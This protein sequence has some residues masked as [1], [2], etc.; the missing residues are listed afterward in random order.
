M[1]QQQKI[2]EDMRKRIVA[3][4][5]A[6]TD[7]LPSLRD[8][9]QHYR[10]SSGTVRLAMIELEQGKLI[11]GRHGAGYFVS[12]ETPET[13]L[14]RIILIEHSGSEHLYS[15]FVR[16]F[17]NCV[18]AD[19]KSSLTV[20]HPDTGGCREKFLAYLEAVGAYEDA[21]VFYNAEHLKFMTP[22]DVQKLT[23]TS[24]VIYYFNRKRIAE[25]LLLPGVA[26]DWY[27]GTYLAVRH[28]TEIGCRNLLVIGGTGRLIDGCR[29]SAEDSGVP[30]TFAA[31]REEAVSLLER[32]AFDGIF[33]TSDS[34]LVHLLGELRGRNRIPGRDVALVGFYNTPW[35]ETCE[36]TLSSMSIREEEIVKKVWSMAN[37][38]IPEKS[39][40]LR[41]S[42]IIRNSTADFNQQTKKDTLK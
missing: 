29:D 42:L 37:G 30:V 3:G 14:K 27:G 26:V 8:L 5:F 28:L 12:K 38:D 24:R 41:P 7:S 16:E 21:I 2:Y 32:Q 9:A 1:S 33:S 22:E 13:N 11:F 25:S 20:V 18:M 34:T 6:G 40:M 4:E 19:G 10:S 36:P 15:N 17:Q 35:C 23:R 31:T 39:E